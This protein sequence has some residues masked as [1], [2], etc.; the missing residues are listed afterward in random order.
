MV[1]VI[2]PYEKVLASMETGEAFGLLVTDP[3]GKQK[4]R[5]ALKQGSFS[6][7]RDVFPLRRI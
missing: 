3:A 2:F 6:R 5:A 1:S 4:S 7:S